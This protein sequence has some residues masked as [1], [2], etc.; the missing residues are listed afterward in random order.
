[1]TVN[2]SQID[3]AELR[4][5]N[6]QCAHE[7]KQHSVSESMRQSETSWVARFSVTRIKMDEDAMGGAEEKE[8]VTRISSTPFRL[9]LQRNA[10][11]NTCIPFAY[12][13][14]SYQ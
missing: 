4:K 13:I 8:S 12:R 2:S 14:H 10:Q 5:Q 1:M 6:P 9:L 11:L 7:T 3:G